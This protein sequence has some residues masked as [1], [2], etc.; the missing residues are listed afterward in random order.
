MIELAILL[1]VI[2]IRHLAP[3]G[4]KTSRRT[5][6]TLKSVKMAKGIMDTPTTRLVDM[7][8]TTIL[9]SK[10]FSNGGT[11]NYTLLYIL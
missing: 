7:K 3:H 1:V 2:A 4:Q 10:H 5:D 6:L 9:T 11:T 8:K